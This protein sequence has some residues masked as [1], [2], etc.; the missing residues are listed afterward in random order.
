MPVTTNK[1]GLATVVGVYDITQSIVYV[2]RGNGTAQVTMMPNSALPAQGDVIMVL[3]TDR[4]L[5]GV[6]L[7]VLPDFSTIKINYVMGLPQLL[8]DKLKMVACKLVS[9]ELESDVSG[10]ISIDITKNGTS[11]VGAT[12]PTLSSQSTNSGDVGEDWT[13]DFADGDNMYFVASGVATLTKVC[14][15][16]E[17]VRV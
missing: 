12:P 3:D 1:Q 5:A 13:V 7:P 8:P 10:D 2:R 14:I 17:A 4:G 6:A 11:I 16:I 15:A 9:W